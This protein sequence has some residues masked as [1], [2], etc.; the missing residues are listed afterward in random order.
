[1]YT[2]RLVK[3]VPV[4]QA[5][6]GL[7]FTTRL[8]SDRFEILKAVLLKN[9]VF[10]DVASCGLVRGYRHSVGVRCL[11]LQSERVRG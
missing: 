4:A 6:V 10:W 5:V 1:M 9:Q 2:I 8:K 3:S 11:H 7:Y